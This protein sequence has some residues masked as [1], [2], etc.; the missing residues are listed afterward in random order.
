MLY[1]TELCHL[2]YMNHSK[3]FWNLVQKYMPQYKE[4]KKEFKKE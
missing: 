1:Y 3:E 4:V 2:K